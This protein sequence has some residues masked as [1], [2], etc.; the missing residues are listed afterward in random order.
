MRWPAAIL[1]ACLTIS[2]AH[3]QPDA[4]TLGRLE[5]CFALTRV[6][7]AICDKSLG[8]DAAK[9]DCLKKSR[10]AEKE[11]LDRVH[12]G[13]AAAPTGATPVPPAKP[14]AAVPSGA[15]PVAL[16]KPSAAAP[17]GAT[18]VA[19]ANP[20]AAAP[21]GATPVAPAKPSAAVPAGIPPVAPAK[22]PFNGWTVGETTSPVDFSPLLVAELRPV[23]PPPDGAPAMLTLRCR[24]ARTEISVRAQGTWR[25]TRAGDVD[26]ALQTDSQSTAQHVRWLL[27]Q[28]GRTASW[29]QDSAETVR[30]WRESRI[31]VAVTDGGG[32]G[33]T[34][35][36]DLSGVETVRARL[37]AA[38]HWPPSRTEARGR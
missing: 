19:P 29:A 24:N 33:G 38:C 35:I 6:A 8:V 22:P 9:L 17:T 36:F 20:S 21:T 31:S 1:S 13:S 5:Q 37:A 28:D 32:S 14:S 12:V 18:P 27:S 11:C 25:P 10:D 2:E 34:S 16:A 26:V 3:A 23:A 4:E 30:A 15:T 7:D